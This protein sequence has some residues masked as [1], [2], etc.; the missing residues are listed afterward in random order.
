MREAV[1]G[2]AVCGVVKADAY[3]HGAAP[4]GLEL[5]RLGIDGLAVARP[6]EVQE[7]RAAGCG[8]PL[9]L[10]GGVDSFEDLKSVVR[11]EATPVLC[12]RGQIAAW[13]AWLRKLPG[14]GPPLR[15]RPG[16]ARGTA[17]DRRRPPLNVV[18]ELDTGMSRSGLNRNDWP[19]ALEELRAAPELRLAGLMS[20][21]AESELTASS[22]TGEQERRFAAAAELLD[23]RERRVVQT[24]LA[25]SS[26]AL[27]GASARWS[28]VRV[29]GA[30]YGLD[31]AAL[32]DGG[33]PSR[34]GL[35]P[36]MS[37]KAPIVDLRRVPAGAAVGYGRTWRA[38]A[39]ATIALVGVGYGDG[40][41]TG[42]G[43]GDA[44]VRGTRCPIAGRISMDSLTVDVT[45]VP[46]AAIGDECV[47]LGEQG[48][49]RID[50][51]ELAARAGVAAYEVW[52][53]LNRRLPRTDGNPQ[54]EV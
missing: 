3:G 27:R 4:V 8:G 18:V 53:G 23:A 22:F 49:E 40:F 11:L 42:F 9:L 38:P 25:N 41:S 12:R 28:A 34:A 16:V 44:L 54:A 39:E 1:G 17:A 37:L 14:P 52:C 21:L 6:G 13:A 31:L 35:R 24:H 48:S 43:G 32:A 46:A 29:G 45:R 20:H 2:A 15:R 7:L 51:G 10:F 30:L 50:T 33:A 47:L 19:A 36:V 26:A 5:E